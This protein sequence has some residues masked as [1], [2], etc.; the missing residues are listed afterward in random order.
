[1]LIFLLILILF[2]IL[3]SNE[4]GRELMEEIFL[5]PFKIIGYPFRL[6]REAKEENARKAEEKLIENFKKSLT[7]ED[8]DLIQERFILKSYFEA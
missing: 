4:R 3:Y 8:L 6:A 2:A 7:K 1:M 5:L